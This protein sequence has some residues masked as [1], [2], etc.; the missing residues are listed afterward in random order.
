MRG[1][2]TGRRQTRGGEEYDKGPGGG[3]EK[4]T[5]VGTGGDGRDKRVGN[6][7]QTG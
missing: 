3:K 6:A 2:E 4:H 1:G 7:D 5:S